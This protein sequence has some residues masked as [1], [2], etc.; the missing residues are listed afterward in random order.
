MDFQRILA[1]FQVISQRVGIRRQLAFLADRQ[2]ADF[3]GICYRDTE[4]E[5]P[6]FRTGHGI[7]F[8][9][10]KAGRHGVHHFFEHRTVLDH[11]CN[12]LEADSGL[13][14]V[15]NDSDMLF[16]IHNVLLLSNASIDLTSLLFYHGSIKMIQNRRIICRSGISLSAPP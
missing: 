4:N 7:D 12:I 14:E 11:R 15:L 16:K 5:S 8:Q 2:K 1:V 13:R 6:G 3:Q 10:T 9:I